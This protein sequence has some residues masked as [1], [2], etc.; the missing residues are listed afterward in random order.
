MA[1]RAEQ[2]DGV[3]RHK[4]RGRDARNDAL[5]GDADA[6]PAGGDEQVEHC[7]EGRR[8]RC[9]AVVCA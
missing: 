9:N 1:I 2:E 6:G 5:P 4:S 7:R 8:Q 3:E